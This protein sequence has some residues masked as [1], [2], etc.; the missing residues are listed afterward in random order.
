MKLIVLVGTSHTFQYPGTAAS[1]ELHQFLERLCAEHHI[2]AICEE[3]NEDALAEKR[4][5]SSVCRNISISRN[6]AHRYC[7]P[8]LDQRKALG[9]LQ[10]NPIRIDGWLKGWSQKKIEQEVR[11]SHSIRERYWSDQLAILDK[12]PVLFVCG[13]EHTKPFRSLLEQRGLSIR[14]AACDWEPSSGI[15]QAAHSA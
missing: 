3:L 2:A 9:I 5:T 7:D 10:E 1:V 6:I 15:S 11:A 4:E 12:W 14:I 8:N 13:A